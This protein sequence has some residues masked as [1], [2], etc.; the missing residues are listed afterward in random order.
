MTV[1]VSPVSRELVGLAE[2][3]EMLGV[4]R[5]RV[6]QLTQT[7]G[8]PAPVAT[9]SAGRIYDREAVEAWARATGRLR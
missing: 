4:T 6:H 8:F 7:P 9:L 1:Y 5:Q 3:A 2:I